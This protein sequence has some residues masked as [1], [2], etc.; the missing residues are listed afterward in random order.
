MKIQ[1]VLSAVLVVF[2]FFS[3]SSF[4]AFAEEAPQIEYTTAE[5]EEA[6]FHAAKDPAFTP[7]KKTECDQQGTIEAIEYDAPAYAFNEILGVDE[8]IHKKLY[9]YLPYGYDPSTQY[10]IL[11]LMHGG[12]ESQEY[13]LGKDKELTGGRPAFGKTTQ[14][15]L[16]HMIQEGLCDPLIVVSPTFYSPVDGMEITLDQVKAFA[17]EID[18]FNY[19]RVD[20]LYTWFFRYE[21]RNDIIPLVE[22]SFSTYAKGDVSE[23]NLIATRDHRAYAGLSMGSI[24][25]VHSALMG[26]ADII[27]YVGSWSGIKTNFD[28][29]KSTMEDQ[30]ADYPIKYWYNGEGVDDIAFVEHMQFH[31]NVT[32][33]MADT[34]RDGENYA[35]VVLEDGNHGWPSWIIELYNVL[36]VFFKK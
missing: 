20:D 3:M 27:A 13:W 35:M 18:E 29:F 17:D 19:T 22:S 12:G 25:S 28:L 7:Y 16:D 34:F 23:E 6:F 32:S 5:Y 10:N 21:L 9:V 11:Y 24:T 33:Q 30:F 2:M 1:K 8:I 14:N 31:N 36:L 4:A 26:C 15:V